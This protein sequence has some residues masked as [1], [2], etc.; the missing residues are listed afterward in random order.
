MSLLYILVKYGTI[1]VSTKTHL[2]TYAV[3]FWGG[4]GRYFVDISFYWR[5]KRMSSTTVFLC[6]HDKARS[7]VLVDPADG[8]QPIKW[9]PEFW[10]SCKGI[11]YL[12]HCTKCTTFENFWYMLCFFN[13]CLTAIWYITIFKQ[14]P[15]NGDCGFLCKWTNGQIPHKTAR[16]EISNPEPTGGVGRHAYNYTA[17]LELLL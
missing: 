14:Q 8:H 2:Q 3:V 9:E 5:K 1:L 12:F 6:T 11:K 10:L 17:L 7:W 16:D 15:L 4:A 13:A